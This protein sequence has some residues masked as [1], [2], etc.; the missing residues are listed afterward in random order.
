MQKKQP[1]PLTLPCPRIH[2]PPAPRRPHLHHP[3]PGL[4]GDLHRP[5]LRSP[6]GHDELQLH[7]ALLSQ[8]PK[9]LAD[10]PLFLQGGDDHAQLIQL[11]HNRAV[12]RETP[13]LSR[14]CITPF[15]HTPSSSPLT[16]HKT[17]T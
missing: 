11:V 13:I 4:P 9:K 17:R 1:L 16:R 7:P 10:A 6:V 15:T 8:R 5:I 12:S 3:C 2:L 14:P